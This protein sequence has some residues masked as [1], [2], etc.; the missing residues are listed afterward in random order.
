V[1]AIALLLIG[2][3]L[4]AWLALPGYEFG[5]FG[6]GQVATMVAGAAQVALAATL[7]LRVPGAWL[8]AIGALG[9]HLVA[10]ALVALFLL[11]F[12]A[13]PRRNDGFF[14]SNE[15]NP[16]WLAIVVVGSIGFVSLYALA[17]ASARER[18]RAPA[19]SPATSAPVPR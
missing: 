7:L 18:R 13:L 16:L 19:R 1:L 14:G 10:L 4:S 12:E 8:V 6:D 15:F 3:A 5:Q 9:V 2:A 11:W 17:I